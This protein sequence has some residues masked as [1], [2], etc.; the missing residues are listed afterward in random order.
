MDRQG[1]VRWGVLGT[2]NIARVSFLPGLREAGGGIA[3]AVAGRERA[4]TETYAAEN[5]VERAVA[6]YEALLADPDIDAV[7]N[8]LPNSLH[9]EWTIRALEAGKAVLTEKPLCVSPVETERVLAAARV[10]GRLL[11]EAFVFPFQPQ[12]Q[13]LRALLAEGAIGETREIQSVFY[14]RLRS[15]ENI[16]L[17]PELAGG[18]LNDVGCYPLHLA[19]LL[20]GEEPHRTQTAVR[21][22]P[23]GVDVETAG[24]SEFSDGRLLYFGC[25]MDRG[26][27]TFARVV[28]TEG[29][30]RLSHPFH[31]RPEDTLALCRP[32]R[33]VL[34]ERPT[35]H[36]R[37]FSPA[38]RHIHEVLRAERAPEH[39]AVDDA[40][41]TARALEQARR[42]GAPRGQG[43]GPG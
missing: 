3:V 4:R 38:I 8:P 5:G 33:S 23:G 16:R 27:D 7:Y 39:L 14:F 25:G 26:Y 22:H 1:R 41:A 24:L 40:L 17:R 35:R 18:A 31:P 21:P 28:G 6:S 42:S 11:W 43:A 30:I 13:R 32:D 15:Q 9:A 37:P 36:E 29:E 12:F 10:P 34:I 2:A 19:C 20:F